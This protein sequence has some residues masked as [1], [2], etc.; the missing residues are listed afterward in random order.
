MKLLD[1][2]ERPGRVSGRAVWEAAGKCAPSLSSPSAKGWF[3]GDTL[4]LS[5]CR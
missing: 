4:A 1:V 5:L 2:I 3:S